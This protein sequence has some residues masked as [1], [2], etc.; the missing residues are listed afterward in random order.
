MAAA[1]RQRPY[2]LPGTVTVDAQ[3]SRFAIESKSGPGPI[4]SPPTCNVVG[5]DP[6]VRT[7]TPD[8][9]GERP[10]DPRP[11]R[12]GRLRGGGTHAVRALRPRQGAGWP[13]P[14]RRR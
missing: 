8:E 13:L 14:H 2:V 7:G 5:G 4:W 9:A 10:Y 1:R 3:A 11:E 12:H 6:A